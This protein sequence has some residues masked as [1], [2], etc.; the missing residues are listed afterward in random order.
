M[1]MNL[2]LRDPVLIVYNRPIIPK[3]FELIDIRPFPDYPLNKQ[4]EI[5]YRLK[6]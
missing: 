2:Y 5:V 6:V 1:Q 4:Y 3:Q